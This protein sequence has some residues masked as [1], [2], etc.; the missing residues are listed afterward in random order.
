MDNR[1][2]GMLKP[3]A[4]KKNLTGN[5]L[6]MICDAGFRIAGIKSLQFND[7]MVRKFYS[8]HV[9]KAF[10]PGLHAYITGGPVIALALEKENA[11]EDFRKLIGETDPALAAEGT[12]RKAFGESKTTNTVHGSD[13]PESLATEIGLVFNESDLFFTK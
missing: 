6:K 10:F 8:M 9:E 1:T 12:I 2:Y 3:D 13:S 5:I 4:V 7:E 11:I